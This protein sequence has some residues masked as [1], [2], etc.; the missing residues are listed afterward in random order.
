[1]R[2][3]ILRNTEAKLMEKV[4]NDVRIEPTL[5]PTADDTIRGTAAESAR[6][7]WCNYDKTF[8]D[9]AV[10]HP[11]AESHMHKRVDKLYKEFKTRK[12]TKY[13]ER[14]NTNELH[15]LLWFSQSRETLAANSES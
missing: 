5:I 9:I 12:K 11:N 2:H 4:C 10:T 1:M 14:I 8:F 13:A 6:G 15:S 3:N 7:I